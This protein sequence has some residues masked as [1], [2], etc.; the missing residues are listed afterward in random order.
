MIPEDFPSRLRKARKGKGLSQEDAAILLEVSQPTLSNWETGRQPP[1]EDNRPVVAAFMEISER[2]L[3][4]LLAV[5]LP[6]L[7]EI[8]DELHR[9]V[10]HVIEIARQA[11]RP[12]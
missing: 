12:D 3:E 7:D 9:L 10:D 5:P 4:D 8:A 6:G 2:D 1:G 11:L